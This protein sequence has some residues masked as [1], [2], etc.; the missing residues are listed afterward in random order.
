MQTLIFITLIIIIIIIYPL[1]TKIVGAP[2]MILQPVSSIFLCSPPPFGSWRTQGLSISLMLSSH[3]FLCLPRG[4]MTIPLQF[5]SLY[6]GQEVFVWSDCLLDLDTDFLVGNMVF[7]M[8][9]IVS[10]GSTLFPWLVFF[11]GALL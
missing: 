2:Q 7:F 4:D 9:C 1:T 3:L 5:V 6:D 8:R 11:C 10:C